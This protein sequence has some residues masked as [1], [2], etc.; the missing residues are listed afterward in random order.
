VYNFE[1]GAAYPF[2]RLRAAAVV[3]SYRASHTFWGRPATLSVR[4]DG[5]CVRVVCVLLASWRAGYVGVVGIMVRVM[6]G[7]W[8]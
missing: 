7:S 4:A 8:V 5:R 6:C 3:G 2:P 1:E